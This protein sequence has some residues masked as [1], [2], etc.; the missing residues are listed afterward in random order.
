MK[1]VLAILLT[2]VM[3]LSLSM[4]AFATGLTITMNEIGD[5]YFTSFPQTVQV[6][7]AVSGFESPHGVELKLYVNDVQVGS[8]Q[9][10]ATNPSSQNAIT[11]PYNFSFNWAIAEP[12]I[13]E[14]K[15]TAKQRSTTVEDLEEVVVSYQTVTA[16]YPA[17]P[18]VA[19]ELLSEA[20]LKA[21]YGK[22]GNYIS[23]VA[24]EMGPGATFKG[25]QKSDVNAYRNAVKAFLIELGADLQ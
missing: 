2:L 9:Q 13:Y 12:N 4:T 11:S 16:T 10:Y 21:K 24:K 3:V 20:G 23:D 7:G 25:I 17:A 14:V 6:T 15:V 5:L 19:A 8:T 1:K 22:N 18:A